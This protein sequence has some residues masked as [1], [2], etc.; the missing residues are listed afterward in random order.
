MVA[1][2]AHLVG[3]VTLSVACA[4]SSGGD[5]KP[6]VDETK[7]GAEPWRSEVVDDRF[8]VP[9][10]RTM[11][12]DQGQ[13]PPTD[14]VGACKTWPAD[15]AWAE[16]TIPCGPC[17]FVFDA[18]ATGRARERH[19]DACC[20]AVSSPPPPP[21]PPHSEAPAFDRFRFEGKYAPCERHGNGDCESALELSADGTLTL[22]PWGK[23]GSALLRAHATE[24]DV[25]HAG[26]VFAAPPLLAL[27]GRTP[28][29]EGSKPT[30]ILTLTR[31]DTVY[32]GETGYCNDDPVGNVRGMVV[33][34][35]A[36]YFPDHTPVSPPV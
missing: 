28:P 19:G 11:D 22:D 24:D 35:A 25:R 3:T 6:V 30:E 23:P 12:L 20:Y 29:C 34:L 1:R 7:D 36:K 32:R 31:G 18:K 10:A 27:L 17:G 16:N 14:A 26:A 5:S 13:R 8:C 4:S 9:E 33:E 15:D 21:P 2:L